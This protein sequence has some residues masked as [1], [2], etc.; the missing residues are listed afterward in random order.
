MLSNQVTENTDD[1]INK[2]QKKQKK[3]ELYWEI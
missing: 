1:E 2:L 3:K